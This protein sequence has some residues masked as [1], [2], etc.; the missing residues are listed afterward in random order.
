MPNTTQE[1]SKGHPHY[2]TQASIIQSPKATLSTR[3]LGQESL[4]L[5]Q[6]VEPTP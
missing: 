1:E 4:D 6:L 2:P 3:R 5:E